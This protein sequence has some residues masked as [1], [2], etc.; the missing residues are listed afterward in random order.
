MAGAPD[1]GKSRLRLMQSD[2]S[3]TCQPLEFNLGLYTS[4]TISDTP[5]A[6]G[7]CH[8]GLLLLAEQLQVSN[9]RTGQIAAQWSAASTLDPPR[10]PQ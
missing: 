2:T 3:G 10:F 9:N 7:V 1:P 8:G 4:K 6:A 5:H